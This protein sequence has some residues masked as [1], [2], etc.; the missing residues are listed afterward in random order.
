VARDRLLA[1]DLGTTSVR[2][3]VVAADGSVLGRAAEPLDTLF[4]LPGRV[5]QD[6]ER[7]WAASV[8]VLRGAL[9]EARV[10]AQNVA[11]LGLVAQRGTCLAWDARTGAPLSPAIGWQDRRTDARVAELNRQGLPINALASATKLQWLA[12]TRV[13]IQKAAERGR[14]RMGT[15]DAWLGERL[16]GGVATVTDP[17]QAGA[18]ALLNLERGRWSSRIVSF[19]GLDPEWLPD[20]VPT[21]TVV[22]ETPEDLLGAAI[23]LAA[24]AGDQQAAAFAQGVLYEGEVKLTLGTSAMADLCTGGTPRGDVAGC[25]A[26]PLWTLADGARAFCLEGT[27]ITAAAAVDW[28][29]DVGLLGHASLLDEVAGAVPDAHGVQLVPALQGLGSPW[30]DAGARGL[31]TGLTRGTTREHVVRAALE[32]V[33]HRCVDVLEGLAPDGLGPGPLRVDGGLARSDLLVQRIADGL[34]RAVERAAETETTALGAAWL[35]GLAVGLYA[36]PEEAVAQRRVGAR[37]EP[38]VASADREA[39]RAHWRDA[40]RRARSEPAPRARAR[41]DPSPGPRDRA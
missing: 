41:R 34:G 7:M 11:G 29:V 8:R 22:G 25:Y 19:F 24:R 28:L 18:T 20:V 38:A 35:A 10:A 30:L 31:L 4:P 9:R 14:L 1:L 6:P 16:S 26:L 37:F 12:E 2:A 5:E 23:P 15:L 33:A 39:E 36:S 3:L 17:G 40:I 13:A 21:S 32:G 27:V